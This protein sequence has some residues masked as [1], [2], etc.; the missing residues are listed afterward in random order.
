MKQNEAREAS[1]GKLIGDIAR[2]AHM[3]FQHAFKDY[4]IGHAQIRTIVFLAHNEGLTQQEIATRLHLDKSSVT[5]QLQLLEKNGY[6]QRA[7]SS[8]DARKQV[9]HLTPKTQDILK[10]I[11][12]IT[13]GWTHTL[14]QGFS[15]E[16]QE[17]LLH[18]LIRMRTNA[19][20]HL[21]ELCP[22]KQKQNTNE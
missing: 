12:Q 11:Q 10:P 16:E 20:E 9:V 4:G 14:L 13:S 8:T 17:Q 19:R 15:A 21:S 5:S 18:Y 22:Y 1:A 2:G 3:Y 7:V 6:I